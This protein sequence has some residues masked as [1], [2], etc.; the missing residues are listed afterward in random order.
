MS[1]FFPSLAYSCF[2]GTHARNQAHSLLRIILRSSFDRLFLLN[3]TRPSPLLPPSKPPLF[4]PLFFA[5]HTTTTITNGKL[6]PSLNSNTNLPSL[7]LPSSSRRIVQ[8]SESRLEHR[9]PRF[10]LSRSFLF[11]FAP[12]VHRAGMMMIVIRSIRASEPERER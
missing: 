1:F 11:P 9:S 10:D 5:S 7:P 2:P 3:S 8:L 12:L 6:S 4:L